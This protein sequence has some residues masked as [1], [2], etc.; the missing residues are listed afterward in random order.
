MPRPKNNPTTNPHFR[1]R[2]HII[3]TYLRSCG[4]VP[5]ERGDIELVSRGLYHARALLDARTG[6]PRGERWISG[7]GPRFTVSKI[8][9]RAAAKA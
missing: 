7:M 4:L 9:P 6:E 2:M 1:S 8:D 5:A 3:C